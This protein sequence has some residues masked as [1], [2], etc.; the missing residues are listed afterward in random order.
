MQL[1]FMR[2]IAEQIFNSWKME[3]W[4]RLIH[5]CDNLYSL[6]RIHCW[7]SYSEEL[8]WKR[9]ER[10]KERDERSSLVL[11]ANPVS[12]HNVNI[13]NEPWHPRQPPDTLRHSKNPLTPHNTPE[14]LWHISTPPTTGDNP[15]TS[16]NT[17]NPPTPQLP[18]H[19]ITC[20]TSP[21]HA[22]T[23]P[24]TPLSTCNP[25]VE[26]LLPMPSVIF[27][28]IRFHSVR[29]QLELKDSLYIKGFLSQLQDKPDCAPTLKLKK[30]TTP[31]LWRRVCTFLS[32]GNQGEW[33]KYQWADILRNG[34]GSRCEEQ[35]WGR[36]ICLVRSSIWFP[37]FDE[38][39]L[40]A[41]FI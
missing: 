21:R 19:H 35:G 13:F 40:S 33:R 41:V 15:K 4:C 6:N 2:G 24:D 23:R 25:P 28:L 12:I 39:T 20:P 11:L 14:H 27:C 16:W 9:K 32:R 22:Q 34:F 10:E 26:E 31:S 8:P 7:Q 1:S 17:P 29:Y 36:G 37:S 38:R 30:Y 18:H 3:H 5:G